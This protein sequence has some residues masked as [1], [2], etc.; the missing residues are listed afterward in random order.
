MCVVCVKCVCLS[1]LCVCVK[2]VVCVVCFISVVCVL[3]ALTCMHRRAAEVPILASPATRLPALYLRAQALC[4]NILLPNLH[5]LLVG[6]HSLHCYYMR[7][8]E[9]RRL[10]SCQQNRRQNRLC[11]LGKLDTH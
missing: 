11:D 8:V 2:C 3:T 10:S 7:N 1:M 4:H 5:R 9:Y 6:T